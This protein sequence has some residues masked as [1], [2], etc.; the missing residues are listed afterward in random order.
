[1]L[2]ID[3]VEKALNKVRKKIEE[4]FNNDYPYAVVSLKWVKNDLDL[5]RRSG[6][7]F[8][9]RKLKEDYRVGKDGNWLIVEEE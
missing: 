7:D 3:A 4:K 8:L 6:I 9:I 5:K 1:M 2:L